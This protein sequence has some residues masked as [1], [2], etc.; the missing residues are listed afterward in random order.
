MLTVRCTEFIW[1]E[2]MQAGGRRVVGGG[3]LGPL[4]P[5]RASV[6]RPRLLSLLRERFRHRATVVAAPA[7]FGKT[8]LLAQ[9]VAENELAAEGLDLWLTCSADHQVASSLA[10]GLCEVFGVAVPATL[11]GA[12]D[13][14]VDAA[15]HA[16]PRQV[17]VLLDDV[18]EITAGS[19]GAGFLARLLSSLPTNAHVVLS[20]R[21]QPALPLSR[22]EV[23]GDVLRL[24]EDDLSFTSAELAEF[25]ALRNVSSAQ[26][27]GSEGWPALAELA[28]SAVP[29][30]E[31]AY[32]WEEVLASLPGTRRRELALLAHVGPVDDGLAS[33]VLDRPVELDAVTVDL[34]LVAATLD[35]YRHIHALWRPHLANAVA[36]DDIAEARRRAGRELARRGEIPQA[37]RLL[38]DARAWDDVARLAIDAVGTAHLTV[39]G[40]VVAS[41]R[42]RLPSDLAGSTLARLLKGVARIQTDPAAARDDLE[43]AAAGFRR[44]G[45]I[46]GELACLVQLA[47]L[48]WWL[49]EPDR[50]VGLVLRLFEIEALGHERAMPLAYLARAYMSDLTNDSDTALDHLDLIPEG[51][52]HPSLQVMAEWLRCSSLNH[53]GRPQDA[54]T[55]A[56]LAQARTASPLAPMLDGVRLQAAWFLG[57]VDLVLE[58]LPGLVRSNA[59]L[60][61]RHNTTLL[62]ATCAM[63]FTSTGDHEQAAHFLALSRRSA[64][65]EIPLVAVNLGIAE[66]AA[67]IARGDD[68][69]AADRLAATL[70]EGPPLGTGLAAFPQRRSLPLWYVLLPSTRDHW[71]SEELGPAFAVSRSLAR[72]LVDLRRD[73]RLPAQ[74]PPLPEPD[75]VRSLLPLPW[76]TELALG[77]VAA[78]RNDGRTLLERLWP[79]AQ[80]EVRRHADDARSPLARPARTVLGRLP[81]PPR[82][83]LL[84]NILGPVELW[85]DGELVDAPGW[86]RERVRSLLTYLLLRSPAHRDHLAD[87][88]WPDLDTDAQSRNLRVTLSHLLR[89]IEPERAHRDASF[90]VRPHGK[91][92]VLHVG[93][94]LDSDLLRFDELCRRGTEADARGLPS[95]ALHA[96]LQAIELWRGYPTELAANDW[97]L[98]EAEERRLRLESM[99]TR[100]GELLLA[101]G[102]HDRARRLSELALQL[103][104]W[105]ERAQEVVAAANSAAGTHEAG[106]GRGSPAART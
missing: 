86:R 38:I 105:L 11:D 96:M 54:L 6:L 64:A 43:T 12:L 32:L 7:G 82:Q 26:L 24:T 92:L 90:L 53:L 61:M 74:A 58:E 55:S 75:V 73:G 36:D 16:S 59:E 42:D 63:A 103:N 102:E 97:G 13:A 67:L 15:W 17:A 37:M 84:L 81:V 65:P 57:R 93:D 99:A 19:P 47:Q 77:Y 28:A 45:E 50:L 98:A 69:A 23:Q 72:T 22:L 34:P 5:R 40:D 14:L 18:H 35:G 48:A 52:L 106:R 71:D 87:D 60:G 21:Q 80:S 51:T 33:V 44:E 88:L 101:Q 104:P 9:A 31:A 46:D 94:W 76:A 95:A 68:A 70:A 25:A 1:W 27:V 89:V 83:R 49:E 62:A 10:G 4:A 20:G 78:D 41:W 85:R 30:I 91:G 29:G 79:S 39:A 56:E 66:S 8:T 3:G 2:S 100:A